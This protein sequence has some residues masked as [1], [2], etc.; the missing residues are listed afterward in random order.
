M[1][2]D[3]AG[4]NYVCKNTHT[5]RYLSTLYVNCYGE[6]ASCPTSNGNIYKFLIIFRNKY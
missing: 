2:G 6:L 4:K 3:Q 1:G 5:E